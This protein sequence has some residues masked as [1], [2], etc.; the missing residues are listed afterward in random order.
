MK[1]VL[2]ATVFALLLA[3]VPLHASTIVS[4]GPGQFKDTTT[5]WDWV[6]LTPYYGMTYY[7]A[8]ASLP[9]GF[10]VATLAELTTL[11]TDAPADP[12]NFAYDSGVMG[13]TSYRDLIWGWY[14]DQGATFG[15]QPS[16]GWA[17]H[18]SN[19][20]QWWTNFTYGYGIPVPNGF[21][22][23]GVFATNGGGQVPEPSSALLLISG[24]AGIG[25]IIRRRRP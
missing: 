17:W 19:D 25:T 4:D 6:T 10:H 1:S 20:T 16:L 9:S 3:A 23:L 7:Q 24:L 21:A 2:K 5:G 18:F 8:A 22:D 11:M 13:S 15:G 12:G 14:D